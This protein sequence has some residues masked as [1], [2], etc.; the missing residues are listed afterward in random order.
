MI[1]GIY[2]N[3]RF[4]LKDYLEKREEDLLKEKI[5]KVAKIIDLKKSV[6]N[7]KDIFI[8]KIIIPTLRKIIFTHQ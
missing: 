5:T 3:N 6:L 2:I 7:Q 8:V 1:K 4:C